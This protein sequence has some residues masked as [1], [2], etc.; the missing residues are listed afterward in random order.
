MRNYVA[1]T[2]LVALFFTWVESDPRAP[3]RGRGNAREGKC[4]Y[5]TGPA[6]VCKVDQAACRV[7]FGKFKEELQITVV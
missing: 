4:K 6:T 7:N 3:K 2:L 1:I 5:Y